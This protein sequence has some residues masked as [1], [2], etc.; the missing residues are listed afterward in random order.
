[1]ITKRLVAGAA[2]LG[3]VLAGQAVHA[4]SGRNTPLPSET[5]NG[6]PWRDNGAQSTPARPP[7]GAD[8]SRRR[9]G[10]RGDPR[11]D[12]DRDGRDRHFRHI[13]VVPQPIYVAP[14]TCFA[15][16]YWAY[17]WVPQGYGYNV[18]V[19]GQWSAD[20]MWIEG[21]YAPAGY[22][23]PYWVEGRYVAC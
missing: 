20:G 1:M 13:V 4:Q 23:Q 22:Y 14:S 11:H 9:D 21:H 19:P 3:I 5:Y 7:A 18:W 2:V 8:Q 10:D 12:G 15:P 16:G 17:Q 6:F